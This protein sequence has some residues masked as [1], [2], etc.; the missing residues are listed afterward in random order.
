MRGKAD[1]Y[2]VVVSAAGITPAYA[3]KSDLLPTVKAYIRDHPRV[4]GEKYWLPPL[5]PCWAGSPPR[6]R[7][8]ATAR[9]PGRAASRITPAYAGK[10]RMSSRSSGMREDHPRVCGEKQFP[11]PMKMPVPGSPP[12][13]RG[14]ATKYRRRPASSRDHPRVCGEKIEC[15]AWR[16]QAEGSPPRMRGKVRPCSSGSSR[17]WDHPRVC[18]EKCVVLLVLCCGLGSPPRMRGKD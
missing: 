12:R 9:R 3:G 7:G 11:S 4:C 8:K 5:R 14:K 10:R 16:A 15:V 1:R 17:R 18:G 13:M 2:V 6:M